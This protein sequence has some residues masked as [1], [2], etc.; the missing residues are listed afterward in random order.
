EALMQSTLCDGIASNDDQTIELF[1]Q[2]CDKFDIN[3]CCSLGTT[4]LMMAFF[5]DNIELVKRL[6]ASGANVN[7]VGIKNKS[8]LI[9]AI[10]L[11]KLQIAEL[12]IQ[13]GANVN[14]YDSGGY[15]PL[16][17]AVDHNDSDAI[18]ILINHG[19]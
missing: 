6:I 12:L 13:H 14:M 15:T 8:H 2:F 7:A 19:V 3:K 11:K 10:K 1:F 5:V 17:Y 16:I 9:V 18:T 4:P